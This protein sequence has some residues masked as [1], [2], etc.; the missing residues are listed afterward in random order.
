MTLPVVNY[1][2]VD[3]TVEITSN[4]FYHLVQVKVTYVSV[5]PIVATYVS[6]INHG[7]VTEML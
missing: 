1:V 7:R 3:P 4:L 2:S 6:V 5:D